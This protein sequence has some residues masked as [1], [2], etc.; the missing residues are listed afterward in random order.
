MTEDTREASSGRVQ[1]AISA[2][3]HQEFGAPVAAIIGYLDFLV[4]DARAN[5]LEGMVADLEQMRLAATQLTEMIERIVDWSGTHREEVEEDR[6]ALH[7]RL[8]HDL[9]TPLNAL[10]G[11]G[12]LLL[13]EV[14]DSNRETVLP[15]LLRILDLTNRLL[16]QFDQLFELA[17]LGLDRRGQS[18]A[19]SRQAADIVGRVLAAVKAVDGTD[20]G[21]RAGEA[22][23]L[24]VVDDTPAARE[25]LARRLQR[26]GHDVVTTDTGERAL[27]L[28]SGGG[29]DLVLLDLMLPG[30]TGFEVLCQIKS[31]PQT[32]GIP[33]I[34]IS[35][36]D[37]IDSAVR[38]IEAG[39]EDYLS[40]PVEPVLL[41]ARVDASLERKR[42]HDREQTM[43]AELRAE[44]E[45]SEALLLQILP[46][47]IVGRMRGGEMLIADHIPEATILFSD[48][49]SFTALARNLA[50]RDTVELLDLLFSAFDALAERSGLEK[51]KTIGDGYMVA[52]GVP[53]PRPDHAEAVAEIALGM[54]AAAETV[55]QALSGL[56]QPLRLRIGL[57]S[58][59]L[60][61]GVIGTHKFVYDVWGD[62]VNTASRMEKYGAPGRVHVSAATRALLGNKYRFEPRG[63]LDIKGKGEMETFFLDRIVT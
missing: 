7:S 20:S 13:E 54:H 31:N 9:R 19:R 10:K 24:L 28:L 2:Y 27:D 6:S 4:S 11:Y 47:P 51:I 21:R 58:G 33:T 32:R 53:E 36:L 44:K 45:R 49:V 38:C 62:T 46:A 55:S 18:A 23:R 30:M 50:P 43:I 16:G 59:P 39:A 22:S 60:V 5:A 17:G 52:G 57:H 48:L 41:R 61:A 12:E 8:R 56:G 29:F 63:L 25:L 35:G 40:K 1:Q 14:R 34:M 42:L 26:D 15:D 3:V 37:E